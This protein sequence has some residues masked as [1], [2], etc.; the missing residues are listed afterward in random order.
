MIDPAG[1]I[2]SVVIESPNKANILAPFM[3][4]KLLQLSYCQIRKEG[5]EHKYWKHSN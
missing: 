3:L 2:W 4:F 5:S 1:E